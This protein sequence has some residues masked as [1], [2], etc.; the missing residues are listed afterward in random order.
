MEINRLYIDETGV[1]SGKSGYYILVGCAIKESKREELEKLAG[2]IK[3]KYW[4]TDNIVFHSQ[5]IAKNLGAFKNLSDPE[6]KK[7]FYVDLFQLLNIAPIV[8]FPV[9]LNKKEVSKRRWGKIKILR[10]V[11]R[12]LFRNFIIQTVSNKGWKGR[13]TIEASSLD[14]D[15]YYHEALKHFQSNGIS[16]LALTGKDISDHIT[17]ISFVNKSNG[18]IEE[19]LAD[20][21]AY[22]A[23]CQLKNDLEA[24]K[25]SNNSYEARLMK[26][27]KNKEFHTTAEMEASK[28]KTLNEI[29]PFV[30]IP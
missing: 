25:F 14:K 2:Q 1:S 13:I 20:I 16:E 17:S 27:L 30:I 3:Y 5:E 18:D 7:S 11:T 19:Q 28:K 12:A 23:E 4:G 21:F 22:G 26:I 9:A 15:Y 24:E 29:D 10:S 8:I 6:I